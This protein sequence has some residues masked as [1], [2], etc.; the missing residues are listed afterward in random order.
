M[1]VMMDDLERF[2]GRWRLRNPYMAGVISDEDDEDSD[3]QAETDNRRTWSW[4]RA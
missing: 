2:S 3:F 4:E 1:V